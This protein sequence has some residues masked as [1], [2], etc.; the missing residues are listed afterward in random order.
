VIGTCSRIG[1]DQQGVLFTV[2]LEG[3]ACAI[4]T[5]GFC[6]MHEREVRKVIAEGLTTRA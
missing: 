3:Y 1:C 5:A 4:W 2:E 6:A